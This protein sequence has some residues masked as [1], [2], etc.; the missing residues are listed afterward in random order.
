[1][2]KYKKM[3]KMDKLETNGELEKSELEK[4]HIHTAKIEKGKT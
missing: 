3:V 2:K 4:K 1:M